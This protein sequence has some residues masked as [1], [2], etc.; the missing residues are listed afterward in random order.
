MPGTPSAASSSV[1]FL[2]GMERPPR[3]PS[4]TTPGLPPMPSFPCLLP[5]VHRSPETHAFLET[6]PSSVA[7][8]SP[9]VTTPAPGPSRPIAPRRH[10][11]V[12]ATPTGPPMLKVDPCTRCW[13]KSPPEHLQSLGSHTFLHLLALRLRLMLLWKFSQRRRLK[14]H[15]RTHNI[16]P[17]LHPPLQESTSLAS[18]IAPDASTTDSPVGHHTRARLAAGHSCATD[19]TF[20]PPGEI[21]PSTTAVQTRSL[22]TSV[23]VHPGNPLPSS[24]QPVLPPTCSAEVSSMSSASSSPVL[25]IDT[26][27]LSSEPATPDVPAPTT[28]LSSP[29]HVD[30]PEDVHPDRPP[31]VADDSAS[32][33]PP[34]SCRRGSIVHLTRGGFLNHQARHKRER[35]RPVSQPPPPNASREPAARQPRPHTPSSFPPRS[36]ESPQTLLACDATP[37]STPCDATSMPRTT[38]LPPAPPDVPAPAS[39]VSPPRNPHG[40]DGWTTVAPARRRRRRRPAHDATPVGL[41]AP[42]LPSSSSP[43]SSHS[44]SPAPS[45]FQHQSPPDA[46]MAASASSSP[47]GFADEPGVDNL[48]CRASFTGLTASLFPSTAFRHLL[49]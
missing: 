5:A 42:E 47:A 35:L 17:P 39:L 33:I 4:P 12:S 31:S 37:R 15:R 49:L 26:S 22:D 29:P 44:S 10:L 46:S 8:C 45:V 7:G 40:S 13:P 23:N 41:P 24:P 2:P 32:D 34:S 6:R 21:L 38:P 48:P 16:R 25:C 36:V 43:G 27:P 9:P 28:T 20:P 11:S 19:I 30:S 1:P 18:Q 14:E 3:I